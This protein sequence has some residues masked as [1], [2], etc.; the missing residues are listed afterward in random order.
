V[1]PLRQLRRV[2]GKR[3]VVDPQ[4]TRLRRGELVQVRIATQLL[5]RARRIAKGNPERISPVHLDDRPE[6]ATTDIRR[7]QAEPNDARPRLCVRGG[8]RESPD[9][10]RRVIDVKPRVKNICV[11]RFDG[12]RLTP[13]EAGEADLEQLR[14]HYRRREARRPRD[15]EPHGERAVLRDQRLVVGLGDELP[16]PLTATGAEVRHR[17]PDGREPDQ[18]CI[19]SGR[20][21]SPDTLAAGHGRPHD[22]EHERIAGWASIVDRRAGQAGPTQL[23]SAHRLP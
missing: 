13:V 21:T 20:P 6:H 8:P 1:A 16:G 2:N 19:G 5:A 14:G 23:P 7:I 22:A 17:V 12:G 10:R 9:R 18:P 15:A 3:A 11:E 4:R